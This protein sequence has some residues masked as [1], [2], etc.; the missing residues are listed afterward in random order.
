[1]IIGKLDIATF[2]EKARVA[3]ERVRKSEQ[4]ERAAM[5]VFPENQTEK[6]KVPEVDEKERKTYAEV[7]R[8]YVDYNREN[9]YT[10][11]FKG[12]IK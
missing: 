6:K 12:R 1:M 9:L 4:N 11:I 7:V 3:K 2:K 10:I 5:R 8:K